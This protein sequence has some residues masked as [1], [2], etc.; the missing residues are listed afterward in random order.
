MTIDAICLEPRINVRLPN[1]DGVSLADPATNLPSEIEFLGEVRWALQSLQQLENLHSVIANALG[2]VLAM[3]ASTSPSRPAM[4]EVWLTAMTT[5]T[6]REH[7]PNDQLSLDSIINEVINSL[8]RNNVPQQ[9]LNIL[10]GLNGLQ[11]LYTPLRNQMDTPTF[12]HAQAII[13]Q[14]RNRDYLGPIVILRRAFEVIGQEARYSSSAR[15][16]GLDRIPWG[17][18]DTGNHAP[19]TN[20]INESIDRTIAQIDN[21]CRTYAGAINTARARAAARTTPTP[22]APQPS[23]WGVNWAVSGSGGYGSAQGVSGAA[24]GLGALVEIANSPRNIAVQVAYSNNS[25]FNPGGVSPTANDAAGV[26]VALN[27]V[28]FRLAWM[29]ALVDQPQWT[30]ANIDHSFGLGGGYRFNLGRNVGLNP[31]VGAAYSISSGSFGLLGGIDL[32]FASDRISLAARVGGGASFV[33]SNANIFIQPALLFRTAGQF[34]IG[35]TAMAGLFGEDLNWQAGAL[36]CLGPAC[37]A[38]PVVSTL[39][40]GGR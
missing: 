36:V 24:L 20:A 40:A 22:V 32:T 29:A 12:P 14:G 16:I 38:R 34:Y 6:Q 33:G 3:P 19:F 5:I 13:R 4:G 28:D 27:N 37:A 21:T 26:R 10:E 39:G 9:L 1:R 7:I 35:P 17:A 18:L 15:F 30:Q 25:V 23:H 11:N 31:F 2:T 8:G